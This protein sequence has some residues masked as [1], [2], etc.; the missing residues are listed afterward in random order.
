MRLQGIGLVEARPAKEIQLGDR[1]VWNYGGISEVVSIEYSKTGKTMTIVEKTEDGKI[2][3]N[4]PR[5]MTMTRPVCI[6]AKK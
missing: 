2:W 5:R 3:Y 6:M 1:L 4:L